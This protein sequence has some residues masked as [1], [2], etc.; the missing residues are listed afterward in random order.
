MLL[1]ILI[2]LVFNLINKNIMYYTKFI[3]NFR[4]NKKNIVKKD[5]IVSPYNNNDFAVYEKQ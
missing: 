5:N 2:N 3:C 1:F 4:K